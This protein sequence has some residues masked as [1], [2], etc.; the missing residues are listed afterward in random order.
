MQYAIAAAISMA[1]VCLNALWVFL[2]RRWIESVMSDWIPWTR[3]STVAFA[4][5]LAISWGFFAQSG[6]HIVIQR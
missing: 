5:G 4:M 6:L 1:F 3:M 2:M